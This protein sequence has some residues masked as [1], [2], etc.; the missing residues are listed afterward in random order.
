[1]AFQS[2]IYDGE[3]VIDDGTPDH[4][5]DAF[6]RTPEGM[7]TGYRPELRGVAPGE[8]AYGDA[9][10]AFP[11]ELLIP[12]ADWQG[13]IQEMEERQTRISDLVNQAKL[14]CKNQQQTNYCW[15]N[16]PT[17]CV[18]V[19]RVI[20]NQAMVI[21]SPASAGGPVTGFQNVGGWGKQALLYIIEKGLVPADK[22]PANAIDRRYNT[23]ENRAL[24]LDY[25][26]VEWW[27]LKPRNLDELI[28]CLLR[29]IPVAVGLNWWSHEVSYYDPVWVNGQIG[30][31]DRNSWGMD[32][33]NAGAGGYS[34]LQGSRLL[35]DDAVA[36]R[37]VIAA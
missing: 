35:P 23:P 15:V 9:A 33:P 12:R 5:I 10:Q 6:V 2:Q 34:I 28:S 4:V 29:R 16:A 22:W 20:Q 30:V 31:R 3:M 19:M 26:V 24:A 14:P 11:A 36:P 17:H 13:M 7:S 37:S 18:E 32:W 21:L 25:R 1:M 8:Y 27:E